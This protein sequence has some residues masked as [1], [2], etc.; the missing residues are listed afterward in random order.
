MTAAGGGPAETPQNDRDDALS[1]GWEAPPIEQAPPSEQ[2]PAYGGYDPAA[3]P[4]YPAYQTPGQP[5]PPPPPLAGAYPPPPPS[6]YP[7]PPPPPG[8][9]MP[10]PYG[11]PYPGDYGFPTAQG[12][13]T[14]TLAIVSLVSSLVGLLCGIG[15]LVGIVCGAVSL[16][17]VKRTGEDG[18]GLAVAGMAIGVAALVFQVVLL[19]FTSFD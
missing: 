4:I 13:R 11:M 17:Q 6:G 7:A 19:L 12:S 16:N 5:Y 18:H 14:N 1:R 3:G 8:Y 10:A 2:S 9:A 15:A